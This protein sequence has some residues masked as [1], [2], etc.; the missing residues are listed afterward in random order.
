MIQ[1][2]CHH[3]ESMTYGQQYQLMSGLHKGMTD[4]CQGVICVG[5]L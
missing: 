2:V 4:G 3:G 5:Q 1:A